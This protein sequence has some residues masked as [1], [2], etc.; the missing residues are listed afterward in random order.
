MDPD[1]EL[2][3]SAEVRELH[4]TAAHLGRLVESA[5]DGG[6]TAGACRLS[7]ELARVQARIVAACPL[8][9]GS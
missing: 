3:A 8:N 1:T 9:T 6:D 7:S 2:H 4:R 5:S